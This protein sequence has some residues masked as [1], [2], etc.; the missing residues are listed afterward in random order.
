MRAGRQPRYALM[1]GLAAFG[2]LLVLALAGLAAHSGGWT[3]EL[4]RS[5]APASA[6]P[7]P[8]DT[9]TPTESALGTAPP[10][11]DSL[12]VGIPAMV[13]LGLLL[14][15]VVV[16]LVLLA[17]LIGRPR[18][19]RWTRRETAADVAVGPAGTAIP[20]AVDRALEVIEDPDAREAVIRTWLLLGAAAAEAGTPAR[21][22]ETAA[23]YARR[24]AAARDLPA[25]SL[26]RLAALYREARFSD[27]EVRPGQREQARAELHRLRAALAG[28]VGVR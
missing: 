26:E 25:D 10:A 20:A 5:A 7:P 8:T 28:H 19:R 16:G 14:L 15:L 21:P 23:E 12:A 3:A 24:L 2:V 22:A 13:I 11:H 4:P 6:P 18:W 27:H 1:A 9:P 17:G